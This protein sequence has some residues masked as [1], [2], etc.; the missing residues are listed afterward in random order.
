[1]E[2]WEKKNLIPDQQSFQINMTKYKIIELI[3]DF[4]TFLLV[5]DVAGL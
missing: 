4:K 2:K 5:D 3:I 1:M